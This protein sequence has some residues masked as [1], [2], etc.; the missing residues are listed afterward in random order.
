MCSRQRT[1][2]LVKVNNVGHGNSRK[3][4]PTIEWV[5]GLGQIKFNA[6]SRRGKERSGKMFAAHKQELLPQSAG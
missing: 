2:S 1:Q 5:R 3:H 4:P 6:I